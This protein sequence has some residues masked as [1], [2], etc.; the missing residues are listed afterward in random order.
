G[1]PGWGG[2]GAASNTDAEFVAWLSPPPGPLAR[3]DLPPPAGGGLRDPTTDCAAS[4]SLV[5]YMQL[6]ADLPAELAT[7]VHD[8]WGDPA[9]DPDAR[10][11]AFR[12][13]VSFC[14]NIVVA[15]PPDRGRSVERRADYHDPALPP[16]HALLAFW[17]WLRHVFQADALVHM[18]AHSTLE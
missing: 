14:D 7:R 9:D 4:L 2:G 17:L 18:G 15:L 13:R 1:S 16:R 6:L 12:F 3:A 11:G 8:A 5:D 10:N